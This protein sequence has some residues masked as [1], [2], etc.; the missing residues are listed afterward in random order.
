MNPFAN[1]YPE[2]AKKFFIQ[3]LSRKTVNKHW[4]IIERI[5]DSVRHESDY[6]QLAKMLMST[7]EAGFARSIDEHKR[8]LKDAGIDV[9]IVAPKP[10]PPKIFK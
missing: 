1:Q 10:K 6:K 5:C 3:L 2:A 4:H 7:Y 9:N 8:V